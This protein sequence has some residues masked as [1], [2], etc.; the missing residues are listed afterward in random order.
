MKTKPEI[1]IYTDGAASGNPGPGGY[2]IVMMSG[3]YRKELSQGFR[4]TTNNRM[5]LLAIIVALETLKIIPS[6]VDIYTDSKYVTD[7][8]QKGWLFSWEQKQ[9]N[10]KKNPDL[11]KRFLEIYRKHDVHFH[12]VKGHANIPENERCD[13]LAVKSSQK[14]ESLLVDE[15]FEA[16]EKAE[17]TLF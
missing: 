6:K 7:A 2:G 15:L 5:E 10:K 14:K 4:R 16:N 13:F 1:V 9:F 3:K 11:W 12:W 8:V 17:D